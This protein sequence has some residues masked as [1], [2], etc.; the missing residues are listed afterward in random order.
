MHTANMT[1]TSP[2]VHD[3]VTFHHCAAEHPEEA[4]RYMLS[5]S[6]STSSNA[7]IIDAFNAVRSEM[8]DINMID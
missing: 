6:E 3:T 5:D 4:M 2:H 8:L 1:L 7:V